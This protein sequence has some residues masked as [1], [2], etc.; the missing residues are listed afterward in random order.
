MVQHKKVKVDRNGELV[1]LE[2]RTFPDDVEPAKVT[3]ANNTIIKL[4]SKYDKLKPMVSVTIPCYKEE[5]EEAGME[6]YELCMGILGE[7]SDDLRKQ[8]A[9]HQGKKKGGRG[10]HSS[11]RR[12]GYAGS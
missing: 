5:V 11:T 12:K 1:E 6:A 9:E 10:R 4:G 2:V 8:I 7:V 3:V